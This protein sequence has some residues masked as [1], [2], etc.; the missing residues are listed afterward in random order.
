MQFFPF[1]AE[2]ILTEKSS[3]HEHETA[4]PMGPVEERLMAAAFYR[5]GLAC[6]RDSVDAKLSL[7]NGA[8]QSFLTRQRQPAGR[9]AVAY[10]PK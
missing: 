1:T 2:T 9:K 6:H 7:M 10:K 4:R 3:D 5:L 8:G